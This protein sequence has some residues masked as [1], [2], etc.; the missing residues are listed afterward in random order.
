MRGGGMPTSKLTDK[1][2]TTLDTIK[3]RARILLMLCEDAEAGRIS[4]EEFEKRV[5]K[6]VFRGGSGILGG[7]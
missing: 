3:K 7:L 1:Q 4:G 5:S 2:R 6:M